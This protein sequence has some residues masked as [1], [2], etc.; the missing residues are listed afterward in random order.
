MIQSDTPTTPTTQDFDV[1]QARIQA[2]TLVADGAE[3]M[4]G[5]RAGRR[6]TWL[7]GFLL[8]KL[9]ALAE[10]TATALDTLELREGQATDYAAA[11]LK[12][13]QWADGDDG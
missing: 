12:H 3:G 4:E 5:V 10:L 13:A 6:L 7:E 11:Y 2:A 9:I 1:A 8:D